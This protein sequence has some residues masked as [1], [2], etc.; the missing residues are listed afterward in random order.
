MKLTEILKFPLAPEQGMM[1]VM[2]KD[3]DKKT[4]WNRSDVVEVEA[5]KKEFELFK[6]AG[7]MAY[8]VEGDEGRK[9]EILHS[10]DPNIQ[11]IIFAPPMRGGSCQL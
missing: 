10:F 9:G 11:K 6:K 1:A 4:V 3:G 8:K 7:Y 2:N 5:A